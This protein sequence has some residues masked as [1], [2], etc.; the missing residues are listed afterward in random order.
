MAEEGREE[1]P[2]PAGATKLAASIEHDTARPTS[3]A[4]AKKK[5][6]KMALRGEEHS[7]HYPHQKLPAGPVETASRELEIVRSVSEVEAKSTDSMDRQDFGLHH[8]HR[9]LPTA[10]ENAASNWA[11]GRGVCASSIAV[12]PNK[13]KRIGDGG[14]GPRSKRRRRRESGF[15]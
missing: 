10:A 2:V 1:L 6:M 4:K 3:K 14:V 5:A 13:T 12:R 9:R 11:R 8:Y 15:K 7:G